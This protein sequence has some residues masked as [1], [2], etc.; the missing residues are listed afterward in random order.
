[1]NLLFILLAFSPCLAWAIDPRRKLNEMM[2]A[3]EVGVVPAGCEEECQGTDAML[4]GLNQEMTMML[5]QSDYAAQAIAAQAN[6]GQS[7][8]DDMKAISLLPPVIASMSDLVYSTVCKNKDVFKCISQ[9]ANEC[10]A[11]ELDEFETAPTFDPVTLG[12]SADCLCDACPQMP[13]AQSDMIAASTAMIMTAL[14]SFG[15]DVVE[16][17]VEEQAQKDQETMDAAMKMMCPMAEPLA[18]V[19]ASSKC[20][21]F[22]EAQKQGYM[23]DML[24]NPDF[25]PQMFALVCS[26]QG[27]ETSPPARDNAP[28]LSAGT[29]TSPAT[30]VLLIVAAC[31][32]VA[33]M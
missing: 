4:A 30:R 9:N 2:G 22:Y 16:L 32:L 27:Y 29:T 28:E 10:A 12:S 24:S 26:S 20:T 19:A 23:K 17:T 8:L 14:T 18:C 15:D 33:Q 3:I 31:G 6:G 11:P 25:T 5:M 13:Y 7:D 21:S 1:M